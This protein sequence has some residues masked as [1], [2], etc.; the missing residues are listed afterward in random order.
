[1]HLWEN[2]TQIK[3]EGYNISSHKMSEEKHIIDRR[4]S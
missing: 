1:M 3:T 4:E 2:D